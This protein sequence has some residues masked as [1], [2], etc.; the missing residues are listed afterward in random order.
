[1]LKL[2]VICVAFSAS[3]APAA[4][5]E[6]TVTGQ[7]TQSA[8]ANIAV[9]DP[10]TLQYIATSVDSNPDPAF[11]IYPAN[12]GVTTFPHET[13]AA[14]DLASDVFVDLNL[15]GSD[16]TGYEDYDVNDE[17]GFEIDFPPGTLANDGFPLTLPLAQ[18]T[19]NQFQIRYFSPLVTGTVTSYSAIQVPE[20]QLAS[21]SLLLLIEAIRR[22]RKAASFIG[23]PRNRKCGGVDSF[24]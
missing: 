9:G 3:A 23:L 14:T 13:L 6:F 8:S 18:A 2:L 17:Y 12:K 20:P 1:M 7:V 11:A 5:Y 16:R 15:F 19:L 4:Y 21:A 22:T 24:F 10:F